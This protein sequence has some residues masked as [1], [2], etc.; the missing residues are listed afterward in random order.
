M[1]V[2][3]GAECL[4][5]PEHRTAYL[6]T[7][8]LTHMHIVYTVNERMHTHALLNAHTLNVQIYACTHCKYKGRAIGPTLLTHPSLP[9]ICLS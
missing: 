4:L 1:S 3:L 8:T 7:V 9:F 5:G 6:L 2:M